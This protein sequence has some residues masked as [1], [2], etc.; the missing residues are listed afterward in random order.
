LMVA[1]CVQLT[2]YFKLLATCSALDSQLSGYYYAS[3][4]PHHTCRGSRQV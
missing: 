4:A 1:G 2:T 3:E